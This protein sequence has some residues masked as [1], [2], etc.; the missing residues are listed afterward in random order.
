MNKHAPQADAHDPTQFEQRTHVSAPHP[1]FG[2]GGIAMPGMMGRH[3][4]TRAKAAVVSPSA[5]S[6]TPKPSPMA[7]SISEQSSHLSTY[8]SSARERTTSTPGP[9]GPPTSTS[10]VTTTTRQVTARYTERVEHRPS[11]PLKNVSR[12]RTMSTP[13][14]APSFPRPA[15]SQSRR[16]DSPQIRPKTPTSSAT[17]PIRSRT[18]VSERSWSPP[19]RSVIAPTPSLAKPIAPE[20]KPVQPLIPS[21]NPSPA[22]LKPLSQKDPTPSISR[23][24]GRGFVQNMVQASRKL[25]GPSSPLHAQERHTTGRKSSVLDR[26]P[27]AKVSSPSPPP[28]T[29]SP[30]PMRMQ[31]SFTVE[32]RQERSEPVPVKPLK[33]Q[34]SFTV[35]PKQERSEPIPTKP[36]RTRKSFAAEPQEE[37]AEPEPHRPLRNRKSVT[38]SDVSSNSPAPV[39]VHVTGRE[40]NGLGS[41]TT[42]VV[43]KNTTGGE[44]P[45][46]DELGVQRDA[47]SRPHSRSELPAASGAPLIHVRSS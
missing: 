32:P 1:I 38:F 34:K 14:A 18:P 37:H 29:N 36:L 16:V 3:E 33:M 26:W 5:A 47:G 17:A 28:Q 43:I 31:K 30:K 22:F 35:E 45:E 25:E 46:V 9:S 2:R 10:V 15:S 39:R 8:K 24:Q 6:G 42:L 27:G 44:Y 41:K 13:S 7:S 23:L 20:P 11:S 4:L 19:P 12:E 21:Q 40:E